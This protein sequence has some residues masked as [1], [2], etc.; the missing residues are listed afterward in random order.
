MI[1]AS[2]EALEQLA[3]DA[4]DL[5]KL[6]LPP[7]EITVSQWATEH[8]VLPD[9]TARPGP[10]L[11]DPFQTEILDAIS[12]PDVREVVFMKPTQVGWS[13]I[14]NN[15][16]GWGIDIHNLPM[17]MVQ[18]G[19]KAPEKYAKERLEPMIESTPRLASQ[20]VRSSSRHSGSTVTHKIF[21]KGGSLF[22]A[23]GS[24]SREQR[25]FQ[26]RFVIVDEA[27]AI[28]LFL[29]NMGDPLAAIRRRG[30]TYFD[31]KMLIG[32]T[33]D[34]PKGRSRIERAYERSSKGRY[35]VQCPHCNFEQLYLWRDPA[36][37]NFQFIYE[38][39]RFGQ[40]VPGS[41]H[42]ACKA[43]GGAIEER[44]KAPMVAAGRWIHD[45][46]DM[47][48]IRGFHLNAMYS[49][50]K[51]NWEDIA[52]EWINAQDDPE[53]LH[54]FFA[55][56]LAIPYEEA[57]EALEVTE[58]R[59]RADQNRRDRGTIPDGVAVLTAMVDVQ[60]N[61]LEGQVVGF[62]AL[63]RGHL[64]DFERLMGDPLQQDAWDDLE[65]WLKKP[66]ALAN[67]RVLPISITLVDSGGQEGATEQVYRF[68]QPRQGSRRRVFASKGMD[69]LDRPGL[70]K[71]SSS[72]KVRVRLFILATWAAKKM[73]FNR[74]SMAP[75][76]P[77]SILLPDW[78]MD[79]YLEQLTAEQWVPQRDS[80]GRMVMAWVQRGKA[81]NEAI[82]LWVGNLCG[83]WIL[84]N[85]IAPGVF[86]DLKKLAEESA[87]PLE[88][89]KPAPKV[90]QPPP[91]RG[92]LGGGLGG[93]G[94]G[95]FGGLGGGGF[96]NRGGSW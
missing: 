80:K 5:R 90:M 82:D 62:D 66:R 25:S 94:A 53:Q 79:D 39:D 52:Q 32:S 75:E 24:N 78:A 48:R 4:A 61:R 69:A 49:L 29:D 77:N 64:V 68:V 30:D 33:P 15:T 28:P 40:V 63:G 55:Q 11:D 67:G 56:R 38:K 84:Q 26:S 57:G 13:E 41:V 45:R 23:S 1:L 86:K 6:W 81:R 83:L 27:D 14:C 51:D 34:L 31:F 9:T 8:R 50:A 89:L 65:D 59:K 35:F 73:L 2:Q 17:L 46:P 7:S 47:R 54:N 70:A 36:T 16:I 76:R 19:G 44:W 21:R 58:L 91:S 96:G 72:R 95:G 20:L 43:C 12:D 87:Q 85:L 71:E 37:G 10:W 3:R 18:P 74:L 42:F 92:P 60:G 22:V 88:E 93:M